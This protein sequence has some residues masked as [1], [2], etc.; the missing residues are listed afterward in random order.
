[1]LMV[2][3][4]RRNRSEQSR[5]ERGGNGHVNDVLLGIAARS[6]YRSQKRDD[7][8]AAADAEQS[9]HKT[10]DGAKGEQARNKR[11]IHYVFNK[12]VVM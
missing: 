8:A 4:H 11:P 2:R 12:R 9:C 1:M 7:D 5:R 6:E 3:A 10:C